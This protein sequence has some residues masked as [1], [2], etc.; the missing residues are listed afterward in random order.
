M[1]TRGPPICARARHFPLDKL[2]LAKEEF[3]KL[4]A[5]DKCVIPTAHGPFHCLWCPRA[6]V[7][8]HVVIIGSLTM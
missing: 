5:L 2:R 6:Q 3:A 4:E 7:G 1:Q 8:G